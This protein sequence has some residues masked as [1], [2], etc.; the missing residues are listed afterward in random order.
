M[1]K[2]D[3]KTMRVGVVMAIIAII[4]L[5]ALAATFAKYVSTGSGEDNAR[6]AKWGINLTSGY[7]FN[8]FQDTWSDADSSDAS[9]VVVASKDGKNVVAPGMHKE[10][11]ITTGTVTG[12]APE[13]AY[14]FTR[15]LTFNNSDA[16]AAGTIDK[17][18]KLAGWKWTYKVYKDDG[19]IVKQGDAKTF[20]QLAAAVKIDGAECAPNTLP[21][22]GATKVAIGYNWNFE[23]GTSPKFDDASDT[24]VGDAAAAEEI[25]TFTLT[26]TCGAEQI[27]KI[28]K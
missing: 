22:F 19:T 28:S 6:V 13:V 24:E 2:N 27:Q 15:T 20:A 11:D 9:G 1:V 25:G 10:V 26:L 8:L 18:D 4:T 14:K 3:N 23:T 17:L 21:D 16:S 12:A 7:D 5:I